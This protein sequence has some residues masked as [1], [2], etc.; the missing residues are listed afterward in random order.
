MFKRLLKLTGLDPRN[1]AQVGHVDDV[2][3][4]GEQDGPAEQLLKAEWIPVLRRHGVP[5]A[6]LARAQLAGATSPTIALAMAKGASPDLDVVNDLVPAFRA[7]MAG[8][9]FVDML[10]LSDHNEAECA[11]VCKPFLHDV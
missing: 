9:E 6:Y 7:V 3:F 5:R 11:R 1:G 10:V 2:H 8:S 4:L